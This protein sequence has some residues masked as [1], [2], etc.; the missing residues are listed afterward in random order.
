MSK[1]SSGMK[2]VKWLANQADDV[3]A[4]ADD[5]KRFGPQ[6]AK[7]RSL[8]DFL[9]KMS[10]DAA[11]VS[12]SAH[13][14]ARSAAGE[15]LW[16]AAF[17]APINVARYAARNAASIA[18]RNSSYHNAGDAAR[19]AARYVAGDAA[20]DAGGVESISNLITPK[21]YRIL[22][23]PLA[24]GREADIVNMNAPEN[25]MDIIR[26][27][28]ERN[29]IVNPQDVR[30]A[31]K[32]ADLSDYERDPVMEYINTMITGDKTGYRY[33]GSAYKS[34]KQMIEAARVM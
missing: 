4:S 9:P 8:L 1:A 33:P 27:L 13:N 5:L 14:A 10:D 32:L 3:V 2:L 23:N 31:R 11:R 22:T 20:W 30:S 18:A 34:L 29:L 25:V 21:N 7:V 17:N 19:G 28:S 24:A 12:G 26:G 15:D 6:A 16:A